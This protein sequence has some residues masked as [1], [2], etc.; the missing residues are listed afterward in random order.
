MTWLDKLRRKYPAPDEK[1]FEVDVMLLC[2]TD[3]F[4]EAAAYERCPN[5]V[6]A[7]MS[8]EACRRCW[9]RQIPEKEGA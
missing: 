1:D 5:F 4:P 9:D 7:A 6:G 3:V 8:E 2:P